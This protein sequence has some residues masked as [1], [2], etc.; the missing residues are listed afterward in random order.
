MNEGEHGCIEAPDGGDALSGKKVLLVARTA[1]G[2]GGVLTYLRDVSSELAGRGS[3]I[4][5]AINAAGLDALAG[6]TNNP[7]IRFIE[8][9]PPTAAGDVGKMLSTLLHATKPD[10]VHCH[11]NSRLF[12][13]GVRQARAFRHDRTIRL[14]TL[15]ADIASFGGDATDT[16]SLK[17]EGRRILARWRARQFICC[18]NKAISVSE[19][20]GARLRSRL[21]LSAEQVED[22]P[23]GVDETRF[24]PAD[25]VPT[26]VTREIVVG[27]S[28]GLFRYKRYD[29][30]VRALALLDRGV[31]AR[32][33]IAGS[34]PE[35]NGLRQLSESL[36]VADRVSFLGAVSDMPRFLRDV[37]V[38]LCT[39]DATETSCYSQLEAMAAGLPSVCSKYADLAVRVRDGVEGYLVPPGDAG[40]VASRVAQLARDPDARAAMGL[41]ARAR[42]LEGYTRS[43]YLKRTL[44]VYSSLL[45]RHDNG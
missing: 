1:A 5:I 27:V 18:F 31:S 35:E 13:Q 33:L 4:T 43:G 16:T 28:G 19:S 30:A 40:A 39:S 22:I 17:Q 41:R 20:I 2:F 36:H 38:F 9:S 37:D 12:R 42:I 29:V 23:N 10:L 24:M 6:H 15:H 21:R 8:C 25:R 34:G 3:D 45:R 32:L 44:A 26:P 14:V 7:S 11:D